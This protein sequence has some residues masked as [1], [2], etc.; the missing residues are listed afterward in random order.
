M[1]QAQVH[2]PARARAVRSRPFVSAGPFCRG[3]FALGPGRSPR[4]KP[5][6]HS[7]GKRLAGRPTGDPRLVQAPGQVHPP[8][9]GKR[10][11]ASGSDSRLR[12]GSFASGPGRTPLSMPHVPCVGKRLAGRPTADTGPTQPTRDW[13]ADSRSFALGTGASPMRKPH[14][15]LGVVPPAGQQRAK[16]RRE[17]K[18]Q[19]GQA[20]NH[21]SIA[22]DLP[23]KM[24][25]APRK[26]D[27]RARK[28]RR[29]GVTPAPPATRQSHDQ[30][31]GSSRRPKTRTRKTA[32]SLAVIRRMSR[33]V[34]VQMPAPRRKRTRPGTHAGS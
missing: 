23:S 11:C 21:T 4:R 6:V 18:K 14:C 31:H 17:Y 28:K 26:R 8:A 20:Q 27:T 9:S 2:P 5:H 1:V 3:S 25:D 13:T 29:K 24:A 15:A 10:H 34:T 12:R 16:A 32:T 30:H 19:A 22:R 33:K 7:M